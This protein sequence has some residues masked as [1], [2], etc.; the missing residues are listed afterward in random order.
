MNRDYSTGTSNDV[1]F[2]TGIEIEHSAAYSMETLFV[3]G[4]QNPAEVLVL[5]KQNKVKHVYFGA[6][7][8][9]NPRS[10]EELKQWEKMIISLLKQ[11]FWCTLDFD[12][13]Y[14]ED[15]LE[16]GLNEKRKF[17]SM[18]SVKL[19]HL[20]QF[21]YNTIIKIDDKDFEATNPGVWTHRLHDLLTYKKFTDWDQYKGDEIAK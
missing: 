19:P 4:L 10:V 7:Q 15:V 5:A 17:I 6:N 1:N 20:T 8:S 16:T 13:K 14:A 12:S 18:I 9:F 21:N 11:D 2:F 3:V